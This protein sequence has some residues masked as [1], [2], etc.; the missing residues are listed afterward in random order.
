MGAQI[1][2]SSS[3]THGNSIG[4]NVTGHS[5]KHTSEVL[6]SPKTPPPTQLAS[7]KQNEQFE[8]YNA[9]MAKFAAAHAAKAPSITHAKTSPIPR[10]ASVI[11]VNNA[12][13]GGVLLPQKPPRVVPYMPPK[14]QPI[15]PSVHS[16]DSLG[17]FRWAREPDPRCHTPEVFDSIEDYY[18][19]RG[20]ISKFKH[21]IVSPFLLLLLLM[22]ANKGFDQDLPQPYSSEEERRKQE[23]LLSSHAILSACSSQANSRFGHRLLTIALR[24]RR[25]PLGFIPVRPHRKLSTRERTKIL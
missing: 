10:Y 13:P 22:L 25:N 11:R 12:M 8:L 21:Y 4:Q 3:A 9:A 23:V 15:A 17:S 7:V 24:L 5:T 16:E 14:N 6:E 20:D 1:F 2:A 19:N 18:A